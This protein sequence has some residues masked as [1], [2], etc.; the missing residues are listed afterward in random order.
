MNNL[1]KQ[2]LYDPSGGLLIPDMKR[3]R[4]GLEFALE[5][6]RDY[7]KLNPKSLNASHLLVRLLQNL[8]VPLSM[9]KDRYNDKVR[10]IALNL[11]MSLKMTSALSKG[12][13]FRPGIFMGNNISEI[14]I[15]NVDPYGL[16]EIETNW[17]DL[18]PI[19]ILYH[20]K[21]DLSFNIPDGRTYTDESGI[22]VISINIPMLASQYRMWRKF[23]DTS[24]EESKRTPMQFLMEVPLPNMLY[25]QIDIAVVNRIIWK[26][27]DL[28]IPNFRNTHPFH[29]TNWT[30]ELDSV[31]L[32]FNRMQEIRKWDFDTLISD[33]P[34]IA[35]D[36]YHEILKLPDLA[37]TQQL[38][39][40]VV[41]ARL[42]LLVYLLKLN[43]DTQNERNIA[44]L[45]R[46]RRFMRQID[47][48]KIL[49]NALPFKEYEDIMILIDNG[50]MPYLE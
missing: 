17:A 29:I 48:S 1:F 31:I 2:R 40:A 15:A 21:T 18:I 42:P 47:M 46:L 8:N 12:Q 34:T 16:E 11:G 33:F 43:S 3:V 4:T 13:L 38:Q 24:N 49:K 14:L 26:Y 23:R 45:N 41:M 39:W 32:K 30:A 36:D 37:F 28:D 50:I 35:V 19:R 7:Y 27:F 10:D 6:V 25:S 5:K 22:A 44:Q 20:P 9:D